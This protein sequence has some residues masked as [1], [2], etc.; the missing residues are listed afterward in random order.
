MLN[1][2]NAATPKLIMVKE[3]NKNYRNRYISFK[4]Q[5]KK[6]STL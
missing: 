5:H 6:K 2:I 1:K 4:L 3:K